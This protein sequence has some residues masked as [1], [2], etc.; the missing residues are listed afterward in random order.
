MRA[1][2]S[3]PSCRIGLCDL[4]CYGR[5]ALPDGVA[6]LDEKSVS[7]RP[8][9]GLETIALNRFKQCLDMADSD[10]KGAWESKEQAVRAAGVPHAFLPLLLTQ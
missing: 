9:L 5:G 6:D 2:R 4:T 10:Y 7:K 1:L 3:V 8:S